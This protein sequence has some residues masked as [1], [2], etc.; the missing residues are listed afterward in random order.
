MK[1]IKFAKIPRKLGKKVSSIY[2]EFK[3]LKKDAKDEGINMF[4]ELKGN[5]A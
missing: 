5:F 2:G 3:Q 4:V 1:R